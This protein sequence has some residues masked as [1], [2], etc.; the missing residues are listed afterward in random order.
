[1]IDEDEL[2]RRTLLLT[3]TAGSGQ[4]SVRASRLVA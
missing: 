3:L 1:M 2:F 4:D